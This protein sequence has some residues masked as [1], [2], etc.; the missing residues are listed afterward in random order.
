MFV[1][2]CSSKQ[3]SHCLFY[4]NGS[5]LFITH[6]TIFIFYHI[7]LKFNKLILPYQIATGVLDI[8]Q[9]DQGRWPFLSCSAPLLNNVPTLASAHLTPTWNKYS[10]KSILCVKHKFLIVRKIMIWIFIGYWVCYCDMC[11]S[12]GPWY[13][14]NWGVQYFSTK[15]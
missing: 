6:V 10:V 7:S 12:S 15:K 14:A 8:G 3:L 2:K 11:T 13:S 1:L 9:Q 4:H 5:L